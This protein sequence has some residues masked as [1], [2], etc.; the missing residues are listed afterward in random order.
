[1]VPKTLPGDLK[2]KKKRKN[3]WAL[4]LEKGNLRSALKMKMI[5]RVIKASPGGIFLKSEMKLVSVVSV[6]TN[7]RLP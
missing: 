4:Y 7:P 3:N 2:K 1:M 5:P 6:L